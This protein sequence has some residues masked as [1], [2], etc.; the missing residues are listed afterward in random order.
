MLI[1]S[2]NYHIFRIMKIVIF[3]VKT[4]AFGVEGNTNFIECDQLHT[5]TCT[6][7]P[8][9]ECTVY[10]TLYNRN[11]CRVKDINFVYALCMK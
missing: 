11:I 9:P 1:E 10:L 6:H 2:I 4:V 8:L 5:L 3:G 7:T